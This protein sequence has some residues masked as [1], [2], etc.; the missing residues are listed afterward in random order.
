MLMLSLANANRA[1]APFSELF[2]DAAL[3]GTAYAPLVK[4]V[5]E[6]F[7]GPAGIRSR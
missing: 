2:D 7:R 5:G 3:A 4:T 1:F 6:F